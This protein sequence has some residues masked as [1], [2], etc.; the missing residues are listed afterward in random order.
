MRRRSQAYKDPEEDVRQRAARRP[1]WLELGR[2]RGEGG[3]QV[4]G[5]DTSLGI[6]KGNTETLM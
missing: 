5:F 3:G 1:T 6:Y 2:G 4:R